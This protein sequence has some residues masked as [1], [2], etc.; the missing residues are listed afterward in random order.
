[1]LFGSPEEVLKEP[2]DFSGSPSPNNVI[3]LF[4][5]LEIRE[6]SKEIGDAL[7]AAGHD[8]M[9][10]SNCLIMCRPKTT[11]EAKQWIVD[12]FDNAATTHIAGQRVPETWQAGVEY[13]IGSPEQQF[14]LGEVIVLNRS[15]GSV[16]FGL[17]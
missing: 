17:L 11:A 10:L 12:N 16:R 2:T 3:D 14:V 6:S 13:S 8:H 5:T 9:Q 4:Q 7:T 15:D 1:M